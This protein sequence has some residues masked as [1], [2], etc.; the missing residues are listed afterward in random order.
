MNSY[1]IKALKR[2]QHPLGECRVLLT[3]AGNDNDTLATKLRKLG[4][5]VVVLPCLQ[6]EMLPLDQWQP[7]LQTITHV[8]G[9][10]FTSRY[11]VRSVADHWPQQLTAINYYAIGPSTAAELQAAGLPAPLVADPAST[12]G[13]LSFPQLQQLQNQHWLI[14]GGKDP[15]PLLQES[16]RKRGAQI[17]FV[18]G[19][20]R[21]CP[22]YSAASIERL[23]QEGITTVVI[24][25]MSCLKNLAKLLKDMPEHPL[26]HSGLIVPTE[27]YCE[28]TKARGFCGKVTVAGSA[29]DTAIVQALQGTSHEP[30]QNP[31]QNSTN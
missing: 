5:V 3:R 18:A 9:V 29:D 26:W 10:I 1:E 24:Q 22:T 4:A 23:G 21:H 17:E 7:K 30:G 11:A 31:D 2:K 27:R 20:Q 25:S 6:I 12:E 28:S 16:L 13:L 19:Y 8:D 15:R 14:I